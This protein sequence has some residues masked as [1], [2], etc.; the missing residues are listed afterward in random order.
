[1]QSKPDAD[2]SEINNKVVLKNIYQSE[3]LLVDYEEFVLYQ[4][5]SIS[6]F[7]TR[8]KGSGMFV[9]SRGVKWSSW[10]VTDI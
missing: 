8:G 7:I 3:F 2:W 9:N 4:R 5:E 1:M 10:A 6:F